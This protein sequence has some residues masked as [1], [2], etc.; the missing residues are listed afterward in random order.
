MATLG[1]P[2]HGL[3]LLLPSFC[4]MSFSIK[5]CDLCLQEHLILNFC[6]LKPLQRGQIVQFSVV[7]TVNICLYYSTLCNCTLLETY[8]SV[9]RN[10]YV[11][12][13]KCLCLVLLSVKASYAHIS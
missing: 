12:V 3:I 7:I 9:K 4:T 6:G 8:K 11:C 2:E 5:N 13:Y 1:H 10:V